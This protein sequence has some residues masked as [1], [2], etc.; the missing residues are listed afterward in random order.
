MSSDQEAIRDVVAAFE[1]SWNRHDMEAFAELFTEDADFVN[2]VG[3][4]WKGR[5][6]IKQAHE[7]SHANMF[8]N[9]KLSISETSIRFLKPDVAVVRSEWE[10]V[11]HTDPQGET[12]SPR[13]GILTNVVTEEGG[14]WVIVASQNTDIMPLS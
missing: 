1:D 2:V 10:L 11:G 13:K 8:K 9:S 6:E 4:W 14:R 5:S 7:T 12:L 3:L